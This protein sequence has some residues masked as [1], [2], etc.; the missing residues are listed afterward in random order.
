MSQCLLC[1]CLSIAVM[2]RAG[3]RKSLTPLHTSEDQPGHM[4]LQVLSREEGWSWEKERLTRPEASLGCW[5][6]SN[7]R[8]D[9]DILK[10]LVLETLEPSLKLPVRWG[11]GQVIHVHKSVA[12]LCLECSDLF[13]SLSPDLVL[14]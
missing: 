11:T 1:A 10:S 14:G 3:S 5:M 2:S 6:E 4:G 9:E 13:T 7:N 12:F 8:K